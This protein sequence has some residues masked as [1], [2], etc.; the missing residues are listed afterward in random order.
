MLR[1][2]L[3]NS[4]PAASKSRCL[5]FLAAEHVPQGGARCTYSKLYRSDAMKSFKNSKSSAFVRSSVVTGPDVRVALLSMATDLTPNLR[6]V[7]VNLPD[8]EKIS[9][10]N[11]FSNAVLLLCSTSALA[12]CSDAFSVKTSGF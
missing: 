11:R 4:K 10:H 5:L 7:A 12:K 6:M 1:N 9:I 8:P 3:G 2:G